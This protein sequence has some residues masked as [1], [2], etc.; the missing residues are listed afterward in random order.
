[1]RKL[2][3]NADDLGMSSEVNHQIEECIKLGCITSSTLMANAPAFEDGVRIAKQ[4]PQISVGVHLNVIEFAPLTNAEVFKKHGI[5]GEDGSFIEG[6]IFCVP[7]DEELKQAVFEEWDAQV[8]RVEQA[9]IM[10]SHCDSHQHTHTIIGLQKE[11]CEVLNKHG[12]KRVRRVAIPS[13][14]LMLRARK[15]AGAVVLDKSKAILPKRRNVLYRRFHLFVVKYNNYR[16]NISMSAKY[17]MSHSFFSFR[18]F[19]SNRDVLRL[20]GRDATIELM[21]H[22]GHISFQG[23]TDNLMRDLSWLTNDYRLISYKE[24][25]AFH[26]TND[27]PHGL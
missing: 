8:T 11:L 26:E 13:I 25:N 9:G 10:P 24:L 21:C 14:R 27:S 5:V 22:P 20:G 16:W 7:I 15:Q 23:E 3:V 4:Y 6:A 18:D 17:S 19:Y 1:M 12:I 2:I